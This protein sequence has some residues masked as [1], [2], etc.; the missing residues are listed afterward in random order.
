MIF[1]DF[2]FGCGLFLKPLLNLLQYCFCFTFCFFGHEAC[3]IL[4]PQ[5]GIERALEVLT[6][7][8]RGK[9]LEYRFLNIGHGLVVTVI[10][11]LH[12]VP[13]SL[14]SVKGFCPQSFM[15]NLPCICVP[16]A[17]QESFNEISEAAY[18]QAIICFVRLY[19]LRTASYFPSFSEIRVFQNHLH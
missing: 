7:G 18:I 10:Y 2:F 9:S 13:H 8:P 15:I 12:S 14:W 1:K 6:T 11:L 19:R 17:S 3:G 5:P 16:W 4:A